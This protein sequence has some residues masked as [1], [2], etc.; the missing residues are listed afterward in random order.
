MTALWKTCSNQAIL[1]VHQHISKVGSAFLKGGLNPHGLEITI[2]FAGE[3]E[4]ELGQSQIVNLD[5]F[6]RHV[7]PQE[8]GAGGH[9]V[10]EVRQAV[11]GVRDEDAHGEPGV[12]VRDL[13]LP[14]CL[15][16]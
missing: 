9:H 11:M 7:V 5:V 13:A 10:H 1:I 16:G 12:L 6:P 2:D 15:V 4:F 8:V 3:R 14:V